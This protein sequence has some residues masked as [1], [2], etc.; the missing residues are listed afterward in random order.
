MLVFLMNKC[1][2]WHG[3]REMGKLTEFPG[4]G[5]LSFEMIFPSLA[6]E[7]VANSKSHRN[8]RQVGFLGRVYHMIFNFRAVIIL[9]AFYLL[10]GARS[11]NLTTKDFWMSNRRCGITYTTLHPW[12]YR[13]LRSIKTYKGEMPLFIISIKV[14]SRSHF[15]V[16]I[17]TSKMEG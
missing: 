5:K 1:F 6:H 2:S 9:E 3:K 12:T 8:L 13:C 7:T 10:T 11:N 14:N 4:H 17:Q 15:N 16:E